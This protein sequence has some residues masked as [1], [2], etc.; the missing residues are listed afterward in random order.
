MYKSNLKRVKAEQDSGE[1]N[2]E[3]F[4]MNCEMRLDCGEADLFQLDRVFEI[5]QRTN[6]MNATLK[7]LSIQEVKKFFSDTNKSV[8]TVKLGDKFGDYG[9][10]GAALGISD[11]EVF[12]IDE[13]ALSCRAMGRR[14]EDALIEEVIWFAK[15]NKHKKIKI[16]VTITSRN[17]QIIETLQR[18]GFSDL[19][20][21]SDNQTIYELN[22]D[23]LHGRKFAP[24]FKMDKNIASFID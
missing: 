1:E 13:L 3:K 21:N 14:V 23:Q 17:Q 7:R 22:L 5:M 10:I 11:N 12:W 8:H 2:F 18:V 19:K 4:L 20:N 9:V 24:W 15:H 6:Q 16:N